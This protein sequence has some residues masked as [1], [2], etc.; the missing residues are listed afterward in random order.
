MSTA[1]SLHSESEKKVNFSAVIR[2]SGT[3]QE[4]DVKRR[5]LDVGDVLFSYF[6]EFGIKW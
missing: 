3:F 5:R 6:G 1:L 4:F 2:T